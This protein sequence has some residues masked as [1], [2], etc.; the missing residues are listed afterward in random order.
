MNYSMVVVFA[1]HFLKQV[2]LKRFLKVRH[3]NNRLG[4]VFHGTA[5][6][7]ALFMDDPIRRVLGKIIHLHNNTFGPLN[8]LAGLQGF[9]D[10]ERFFHEFS[11][12]DCHGC[13]ISHHLQYIRFFVAKMMR[14]L[15]LNQS[16]RTNQPSQ[17][18]RQIEENQFVKIAS[19][20]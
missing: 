18:I 14:F 7:H 12:F 20:F 2:L 9:L 6:I 5:G 11:V 13:L 3:E 4:D 15:Y 19:A 1:N 16:Q 10:L 17:P 8:K